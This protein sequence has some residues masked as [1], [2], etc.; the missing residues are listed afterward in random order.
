M[1]NLFLKR[2]LKELRKEEAVC[3]KELETL[4][5]ITPEIKLKY[6][7]IAKES[8]MIQ[9]TL[10][11]R[12]SK[13][14]IYLNGMLSFAISNVLILSPYTLPIKLSLIAINSLFLFTLIYS[15]DS[16][17]QTCKATNLMFWIA[18]AKKTL[19]EW[20][21]YRKQVKQHLIF[22]FLLLCFWFLAFIS[23]MPQT[24]FAFISIFITTSTIVDVFLRKYH[25]TKFNETELFLETIQEIRQIK[26]T[27]LI[28]K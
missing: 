27:F 13:T 15:A 24:I 12:K 18:C 28:K 23:I 26:K 2:R 3:T 5:E 17:I 14:S 8:F 20:K 10:N 4:R 16:L 25:R 9:E 7:E 19:P 22:H 11:Y 21:Q 6:I 1:N